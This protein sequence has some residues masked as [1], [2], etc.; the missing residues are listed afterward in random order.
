MIS[1]LFQTSVTR[2]A[3]K[4]E[5]SAL[6]IKVQQLQDQEASLQAAMNGFAHPQ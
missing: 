1:E 6:R 5:E 4:R 2:E 3:F